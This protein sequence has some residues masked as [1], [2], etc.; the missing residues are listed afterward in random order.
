MNL[1]RRIQG[2]I[3]PRGNPKGVASLDDLRRDDLTFIN[4]QRGSG[5][6]MLLDYNLKTLGIDPGAVRGYGR[7]EYTHLGVAAAVAGGSADVG[8]GI[9]SAARALE[10]DFVPLLTEQ[11]DLVV[12]KEFYEGELLQ[13][14][15]TLIR[16]EEFRRDV[17]ALGGYDTSMMGQILAELG[18]SSG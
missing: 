14:L 2:L 11:Y 1:V 9:L 17:E 4:R 15:L 18:S 7:E 8:L 6:R 13:P 12:P 16:A 10:V 5:T 3:V